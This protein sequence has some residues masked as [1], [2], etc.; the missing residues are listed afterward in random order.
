MGATEILLSTFS[1]EKS[2]ETPIFTGVS[3]PVIGAGVVGI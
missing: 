2:C 1:L 3:D